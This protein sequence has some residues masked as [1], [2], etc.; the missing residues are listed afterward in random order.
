[1]SGGRL[2]IWI[3]GREALPVRAIPY[4]AGWE[5]LYSPD[6]VAESLARVTAAPFGKLRNLVAYHRPAGKSLPVM[7]SEW[8]AVIAEVKGFEAGLREP[9]NT[10]TK[11]YSTL[12]K[13][14]FGVEQ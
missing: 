6:V 9:L 5:H 8:T 2:T 7:A 10:W 13:E 12:I 14:H 11:Q 4:V 1:M 3:D